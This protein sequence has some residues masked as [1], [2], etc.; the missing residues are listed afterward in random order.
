MLD[1]EDNDQDWEEIDLSG[2]KHLFK[3]DAD[4]VEEEVSSKELETQEE[5]NEEE[6]KSKK[7]LTETKQ[8]SKTEKKSEEHISRSAKRIQELL[9][10]KKQLK[11]ELLEA[12][13]Q[14]FETEKSSIVA[15]KEKLETLIKSKKLELKKVFDE[16][17][18]D[19]E[20]DIQEDIIK[21]R[22]KLEAIE[23]YS[24]KQPE[25]YIEEPEVKEKPELPEH[26][27]VWI[28]S[29]KE[30]FNK[31][32][33]KT[34]AAIAVN[35]ALLVEGFDPNSEKF[36]KEVDKRLK[37]WYPKL[38]KKEED[39]SSQ[40][41]NDEQDDVEYKKS[42]QKRTETSSK[43]RQIV[44]GGS[45]S[46]NKKFVKLSRDEQEMARRMGLTNKEYAEEK[47]KFESPNE[48]GYTEIFK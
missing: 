2:A 4:E 37:D 16:N 13:R 44:S 33:S 23:A 28:S 32:T 12:K 19:K 11:A 47:V 14:K 48:S 24:R 31:D 9:Q 41:D 20:L 29:N 10:E 46:P 15:E 3:E 7:E 38:F 36:Y 21:A 40:V 8:E 30:W 43:V 18:K 5:E 17:D 6:S 1:E 27:E 26:A 42:S 39:E 35:N 45:R 22:V 25:K 34:K